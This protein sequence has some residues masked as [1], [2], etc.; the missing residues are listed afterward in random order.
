MTVTHTSLAH[1]VP[2]AVTAYH[3]NE[4]SHGLRRV[5]NN[6]ERYWSAMP[7]EEFVAPIGASWS[8]ADHVRHLTRS[9]RA[10]LQGMR[11]PRFVLRLLYGKPRGISRPYDQLVAAYHARLQAGGQAGRFA[12]TPAVVSGDPGVWRRTVLE[13]H[14]AEVE[15]LSKHVMLWTRHHVDGL[16]MPHPLLGRLTVREMLLF[17]LYH[18]QHHVLV[19]AR[20][21]GEYVSDATPLRG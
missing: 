6:S 10:V 8:P 16:H 21:R 17:T 13:R 5:C 7:E 15:A 2:P 18:N 20:R 12:P 1:L 4:I 11:M 9:V 14:R 3:R 19:V